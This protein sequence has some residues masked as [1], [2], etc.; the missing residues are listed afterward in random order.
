MGG[1]LLETAAALRSGLKAA[2]TGGGTAGTGDAGR[3]GH[4]R[5]VDGRDADRPLARRNLLDYLRSM[6]VALEAPVRTAIEA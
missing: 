6:G 2:G 4:G 1:I 3:S 5:R